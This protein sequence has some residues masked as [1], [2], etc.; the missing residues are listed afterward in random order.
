MTPKSAK[1]RHRIMSIKFGWNAKSGGDEDDSGPKAPAK[2]AAGVTKRTGRV[3][4]LV[5][6]GRGKKAAVRDDEDSDEVKSEMD[7]DGEA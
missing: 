1:E 7:V 4:D 2:K 6:K 5:K 3:G